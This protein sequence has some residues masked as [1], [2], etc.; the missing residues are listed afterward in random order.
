LDKP[1]THLKES[2]QQP[3]K[4]ENRHSTIGSKRRNNSQNADD[5][6]AD[7]DR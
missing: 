7:S 6:D 1:D 5:T 4:K 2:H 3:D